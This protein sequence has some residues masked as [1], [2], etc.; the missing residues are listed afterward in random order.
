[1]ATQETNYREGVINSFL[2]GASKLIEKGNPVFTR[3]GTGYLFQPKSGD[4]AAAGDKFVGIAVETIDNTSGTDGAQSA[5]VYGLGVH[6]LPNT[7]SLTQAAVG[8]P[9]KVGATGA[10]A[11]GTAAYNI[12]ICV[13]VSTSL[14]DIRIDGAIGLAYA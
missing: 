7:A 1:M 4:S 5:R 2:V 9:I 14:V 8:D 6:Q 3:E 13:G 11:A 10:I 12:G